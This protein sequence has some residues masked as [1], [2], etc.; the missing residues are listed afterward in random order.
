M[1]AGFSI[2]SANIPEFS[3]RLNKYAKRMFT[4]EMLQRKLKI[5]LELKFSDLTGNLN[6]EL[7]EF[8]PTGLGNPSP[9]LAGRSILSRVAL[10]GEGGPSGRSRKHTSGV[11]AQMLGTW[12]RTSGMPSNHL[13]RSSRASWVSRAGRFLTSCTDGQLQ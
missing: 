5:D 6:E 1:A 7:E 13:T 9:T 8:E 11:R 2:K 12:A 10:G 4:G 3:R